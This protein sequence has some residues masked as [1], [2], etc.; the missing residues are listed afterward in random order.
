MELQACRDC[1]LWWSLGWHAFGLV[2]KLTLTTL[3][4]MSIVEAVAVQNVAGRLDHDKNFTPD[5]HHLS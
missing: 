4:V 2:E 5:P 1:Q 3:K